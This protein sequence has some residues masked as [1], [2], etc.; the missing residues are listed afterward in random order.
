MKARIEYSKTK[1]VDIIK[2]PPNQ[3][4]CPPCL[5]RFLLILFLISYLFIP[6]KY[7]CYSGLVLCILIYL[8]KFLY[9]KKRNEQFLFLPEPESNYIEIPYKTKLQAIDAKITCHPESNP[10][11]IM[12]D[13][14]NRLYE[15]SNYSDS[16][17]RL[18]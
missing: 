7:A 14:S 15:F 4:T 9:D 12:Q 17:F 10:V 3:E 16:L 18:N 11:R 1:Q 2:I 5:T 8:S 6:N 13:E